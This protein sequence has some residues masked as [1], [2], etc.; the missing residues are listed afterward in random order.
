MLNEA[1]VAVS[2]E[3]LA[4]RWIADPNC[5]ED[6]LPGHKRFF[7]LIFPAYR[8]QAFFRLFTIR[9]SAMGCGRCEGRRRSCHT[10]RP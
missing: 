4:N 5:I 7:T 8:E 9:P 1:K 6:W 2:H 10:P 3:H